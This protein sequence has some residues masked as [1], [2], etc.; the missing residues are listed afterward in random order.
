MP[1]KQVTG[2]T[3]KEVIQSKRLTASLL[4]KKRIQFVVVMIH[5]SKHIKGLYVVSRRQVW[6]HPGRGTA[7]GE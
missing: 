6:N 5:G 4:V 7:S 1:A 2:Y 3:S